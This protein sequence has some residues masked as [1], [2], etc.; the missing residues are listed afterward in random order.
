MLRT[1]DTAGQCIANSN[2]L[3][4]TPQIGSGQHCNVTGNKSASVFGDRQETELVRKSFVKH[5]NMNFI[6]TSKPVDLPSEN[7]SSEDNASGNWTVIA[8]KKSVPEHCMEKNVNNQ[9]IEFLNST[10]K[11]GETSAPRW[12]DIVEIEE[13]ITSP[14][15][16]KLSPQ[17]PVFVPSSDDMFDADDMLD[18]CFVKV[19]KVGDLSPR[20][21][22]SGSNK[23]KK[24]RH[25]RKHSWDGKVTEEFVPRNL[26]MRLA[27][28]NHLTV[29]T[30]L[31]RSNKSKKR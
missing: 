30:T 31:T 24:K 10:E 16:S 29:S 14:H 4:D 5:E 20:Q 9:G 2:T 27:K 7:S 25:E 22:R 3:V 15:R 23:S 12:A 11:Q 28:Q 8:H 26:A 19:A 18:I 21:Q 6:A 13:H 17:A 1:K